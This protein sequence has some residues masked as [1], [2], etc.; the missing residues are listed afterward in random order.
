[1]SAYPKTLE[2]SRVSGRGNP[3]ADTMKQRLQELRLMET[4]MASRYADTYR[5]LIDIREQ[6]KQVEGA[7][8]KEQ[9][10][11]TEVTTGVDENRQALQLSLD[12]ERA[13]LD[14]QTAR[15]TAL[16]GELAKVKEQLAAL[17]AQEADFMQLQREVE[18]AEKEYKGYRDNLQ[19]ARVSAA[20][21][22]DK[23]SNVSVVQP[24]TLP[25][26]P[27]KPNKALNMGLGALLGLFGGVFLAF[28]VEFL[29]DSLNTTS[30]AEKR[31]GVPVLVALSEKEFD[32]CR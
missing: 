2:L 16:D 17:A 14:A 27:A 11:R 10:T 25:M 32:A 5:P 29:D 1:L 28:V 20:L 9:E 24:A 30:K 31:L 7:L 3:A 15:K 13:Q 12:T 22:M 21:D 19:R 8:A 6:I 18:L 26:G 4:Q 23:V